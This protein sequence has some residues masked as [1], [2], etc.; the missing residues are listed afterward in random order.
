[1]RNNKNSQINQKTGNNGDKNID[2]TSEA[3]FP[4]LIEKKSDETSDKKKNVSEKKVSIF[5]KYIH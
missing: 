1:M 3:D 2:F 4:Q 5:M